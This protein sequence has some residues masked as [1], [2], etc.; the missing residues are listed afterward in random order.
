M[1][2]IKDKLTF[3]MAFVLSSFLFLFL[4]FFLSFSSK[5]LHCY[6]GNSEFPRVPN[7]LSVRRWESVVPLILDPWA[8]SQDPEESI[9]ES[10]KLLQVFVSFLGSIFIGSSTPALTFQDS[11]ALQHSERISWKPAGLQE[12]H[13]AHQASES[14]PTATSTLP[15]VW[16]WLL[17]GKSLNF[18]WSIS[19]EMNFSSLLC[20]WVKC[21]PWTSSIAIP[22]ELVRNVEIQASRW[23]KI[24]TFIRTPSDFD[25]H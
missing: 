11:Q 18:I 1:A 23:I 6:M 22:C 2:K 4:T 25:A 16:H 15:K 9:W 8:K 7:P 12:Q 3:S 13:Q 14:T 10:E 17:F 24:C 21:G 19:M 20:L 5:I